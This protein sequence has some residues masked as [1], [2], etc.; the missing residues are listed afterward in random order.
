MF[1]QL[2]PRNAGIAHGNIATRYTRSVGLMDPALA[3]LQ[4]KENRPMH[5]VL[6]EV[7]P[8]HHRGIYP[9]MKSSLY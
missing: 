8:P 7:A 2:Q 1:Y 3:C 9:A 6:S 5:C 4:A